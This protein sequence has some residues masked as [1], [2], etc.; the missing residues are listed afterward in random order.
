MIFELKFLFYQAMISI[1]SICFC[2]FNKDPI[3]LLLVGDNTPPKQKKERAYLDLFCIF[4]LL[5]FVCPVTVCD[6]LFAVAGF[7]ITF[8]LE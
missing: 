8:F 6:C 1:I 5:Q 7:K 4:V 3:S 2:F